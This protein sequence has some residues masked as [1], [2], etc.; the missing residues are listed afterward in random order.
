MKKLLVLPLLLGFTSAVNAETVWLLVSHASGGIEKVEM[1]DMNTCE[2]ESKKLKEA[3]PFA[4]KI[5]FTYCIKG[6]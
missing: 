3:N 5:P 2:I 4:P 1:N 6:K